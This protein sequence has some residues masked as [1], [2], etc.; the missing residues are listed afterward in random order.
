[1][2][3][4][5]TKTERQE[6]GQLIRKR[7]RVMKMQA[8]ERSAALMAEFDAQSAKIYHYDDD[9]VWQRVHAEAVASLDVARVEIA[10]RC[11]EL[12]IPQ[13]FAPGLDIYWHGRG[14]NAVQERR[15][16]LRRAAKSRIAAIEAEA[17]SK[18]ER[19]SLEAQTQIVANGLESEGAKAF[20]NAMPAM[21][22]LMPPLQFDEIASLVETK[23]A[24]RQLGHY[25]A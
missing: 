19:L 25:D 23:C 7:E 15:S 17:I 8:Q 12:G 10:A 5:M 2:T 3:A 6:L 1:M 14:H 18:I 11:H 24:Q 22:Q 9:P 4:P 20:L 13:E 21:D 16:E